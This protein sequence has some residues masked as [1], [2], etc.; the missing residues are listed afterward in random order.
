[1]LHSCDMLDSLRV[2]EVRTDRWSE[3]GAT[4]SAGSSCA[5]RSAVHLRA[6]SARRRCATCDG[7]RRALQ[8]LLGVH[9]R[10]GLLC[11]CAH[12]ARGAGVPLRW[13]ETGATSSAGSSCALRSA[14]HLRACSARRRCATAMERDGR[15]KL[16]WEFMRASV[17]CALARLQRAAQLCHCDGAR[18]ALQALLGVHARFGLL[19][20]CALAARGAGVPLRWSETGATSSVGSSCAL[21]SAVHLRACSARRRCATE[22]RCATTVTNQ[23]S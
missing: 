20:T 15:Y 4:S 14:V 5:L 9:A 17:C 22:T 3:T 11:T 12:A 21:R 1:M 18:R 13:S 16:C 8:A 23:I 10:F 6:C 2:T 19:C 7:A